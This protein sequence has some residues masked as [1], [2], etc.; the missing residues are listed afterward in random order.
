MS[1]YD[2]F[3]VAIDANGSIVKI[4]PDSEDIYD[5]ISNRDDLVVMSFC[6]MAEYFE[7]CYDNLYKVAFE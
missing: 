1:V 7:F 5:F 3:T 2:I 6:S 4:S